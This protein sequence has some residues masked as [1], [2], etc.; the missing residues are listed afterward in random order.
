M[1][2]SADISAPDG[3]LLGAAAVG[4]VIVAAYNEADRIERTV[5]A[6]TEVFPNATLIVA[7]DGSEDETVA[8]ATAAGATVVSGG[9]HGKGQA[10]SLGAERAL[11]DGPPAAVEGRAVVLLA[12]ADLADSAARLA[13][14][15]AMVTAD[16]ADIAIADFT[17]RV[18][19]GFGLALAFARWAI[20]RRCGFES[21]AAISGQRALDYEALA[22]VTPFRDGFGM[23]IGMTVD[24]VRAG[25]RVREVELD[26]SH[27]ATGKTLRGFVHR[28]RQLRDFVRVYRATRRERELVT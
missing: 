28:G 7:D 20:Q 3:T 9:H 27:R 11:R 21:T 2:E 16:Q 26:L 17:R 25:C 14:L 5:R 4:H 22:V 18:G 15:A 13:P 6:V 23:E 12:D 19:G 8:V 1:A 10:A 24:A